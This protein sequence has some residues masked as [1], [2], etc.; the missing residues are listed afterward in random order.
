MPRRYRLREEQLIRRTR[1]EVFAFFA[2]AMNL[3][4]ITPKFLRF[5]IT[6][7]TPIAMHA[8][9]LIDYR[10]RLFG[11]PFNW[12]TQIETW[13]PPGRFTDVQL[14]GPYRL[15]HHT[16]EFVPVPEGTLCVDTVDYELPWG[17]LGSLA[18]PLFVRRSLRQI[19]AYRRQTI[20][21]LLAGDSATTGA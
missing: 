3:E 20:E 7:P 9:A 16:H 11:I 17:V 2:D 21:A 4:Q 13:D 14:K 8:G 5:R 18:H 19:F 15:W 1:E 12:R 10:L 6:S